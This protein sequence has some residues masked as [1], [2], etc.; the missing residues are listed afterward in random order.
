MKIRADRCCRRNASVDTEEKRERLRRENRLV[1][2]RSVVPEGIFRVDYP[3]RYTAHR[4]VQQALRGNVSYG[5]QSSRIGHDH[6]LP[7][8]DKNRYRKKKEKPI[9]VLD[10]AATDSSEKKKCSVKKKSRIGF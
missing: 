6:F 10:S 5:A 1:E 7:A 9:M 8:S 3:A 2:V 4:P